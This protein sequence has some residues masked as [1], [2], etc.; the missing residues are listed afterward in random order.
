MRV[1]VKE[2]LSQQCILISAKKRRLAQQQEPF[3]LNQVQPPGLALWL[4]WDFGRLMGI[5]I[6]HG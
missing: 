3:P 1:Y 6:S 4:P 2:V 5:I